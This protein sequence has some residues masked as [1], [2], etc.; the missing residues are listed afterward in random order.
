MTKNFFLFSP[1]H[2]ARLLGHVLI[3]I[4]IRGES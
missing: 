3:S 4:E 2:L 1:D